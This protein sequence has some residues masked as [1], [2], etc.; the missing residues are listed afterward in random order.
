MHVMHG[1][2]L[3][4]SYWT[5]SISRTKSAVPA[6]AWMR[7]ALPHG[8]ISGDARAVDARDGV[9]RELRDVAEQIDH[10]AS[11]GHAPATAPE[12][13]MQVDVIGLQ[14]C[15]RQFGVRWR[16]ATGLRVVVGHGEP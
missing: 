13:G 6:H 5:V 2:S 7:G 3:S 12:P 9:H 11:T 10:A 15:W 8:S 16:R 14:L 4:S 1:P